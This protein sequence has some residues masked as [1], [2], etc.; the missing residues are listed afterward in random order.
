MAAEMSPWEAALWIVAVYVAVVALV[1]LMAQHRR[2][3]LLRLVAE[4]RAERHRMAQTL[5]VRNR[6]KAAARQSLTR[7]RT[8]R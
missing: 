5:L 4:K 6:R 2:R 8:V 7:P 3:V 1:R